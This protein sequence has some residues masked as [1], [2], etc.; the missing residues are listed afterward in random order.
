MAAPTQELPPWLSF[1][2]TTITDAGGNPLATS[3]T[4]QY[5]PLTYYGPSVSGSSSNVTHG[6]G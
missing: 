3:T 6:S 5:L 1:V 4:L 2:T